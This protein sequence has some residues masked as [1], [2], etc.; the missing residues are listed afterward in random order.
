M[1]LR[2]IEQHNRVAHVRGE[3]SLMPVASDTFVWYVHSQRRTGL[4][5]RGVIDCDV[6]LPIPLRPRLWVCAACFEVSST[7]GFSNVRDFI[8]DSSRLRWTM[9]RCPCYG[10]LLIFCREN[11]TPQSSQYERIE[12]MLSSLC[13][14]LKWAHIGDGGQIQQ[15]FNS[16]GKSFHFSSIQI[17][18]H[19]NRPDKRKEESW[20]NKSHFNWGCLFF[21]HLKLFLIRERVNNCF[22][23]ILHWQYLRVDGCISAVDFQCKK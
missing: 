19:G 2:H 10:Q 1:T 22:N 18:L 12:N 20:H 5:S 15:L 23:D 7:K 21:A 3:I 17:Q 8:T 16:N 4:G 11:K 6:L 9:S 13:L 14:T